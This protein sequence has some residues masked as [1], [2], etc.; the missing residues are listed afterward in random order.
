MKET[1]V[2]IR[3]MLISKTVKVE[4]KAVKQASRQEMKTT[5]EEKGG[6]I[7]KLQNLGTNY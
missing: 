7:K 5:E 1:A 3:E 4:G 2:E 6:L